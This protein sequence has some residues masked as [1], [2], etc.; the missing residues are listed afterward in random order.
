MN[1]FCSR[2][3]LSLLCTCPGPRALRVEIKQAKKNLKNSETVLVSPF[4]ALETNWK[5][6]KAYSNGCDASEQH[7]RFAEMGS[8]I[9]IRTRK[10]QLRAARVTALLTRQNALL[11]ILVEDISDVV[12]GWWTWSV[13]PIEWGKFKSWYICTAWRK[14][15]HLIRISG[16]RWW[17]W[18]KKNGY[19]KISLHIGWNYYE[20][21]VLSTG[22]FNRTLARSLSPLAHLLAPHCFVCLLAPLHSFNCSLAYL[23]PSSW[24]RCFCL[25]NERVDFIQFQPTV[26]VRSSKEH[27]RD[28]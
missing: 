23:F 28:R 19:G 14:Y 16:C 20:F 22:P 8:G 11:V 24:E 4:A 27:I 25:R 1:A 9:G 2:S 10:I 21:D 18:W 3:S 5:K 15:L 7:M 12:L 13:A 26:R 17:A 6:E